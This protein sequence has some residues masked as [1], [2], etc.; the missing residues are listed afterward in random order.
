MR[1]L[2]FTHPPYIM[3][4]SLMPSQ[5]TVRSLQS[6]VGAEGSGTR[7]VPA[8]GGGVG[9]VSGSHVSKHL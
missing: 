9:L 2:E 8:H 6:S 1:G 7:V 3:P 5:Q 4:H